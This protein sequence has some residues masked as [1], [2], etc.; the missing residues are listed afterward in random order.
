LGDKLGPDVELLLEVKVVR[1]LKTDSERHLNTRKLA[2][3]G[4]PAAARG[5]YVD[6]TEDDRHLHLVRVGKYESVLRTVPAGI[7][8][9]GIHMSVRASFG[10]PL[11]PIPSR[12]PK[13]HGFAEDVVVYEP[14]EHG[15]YTHE[16]DDV[17][18]AIESELELSSFSHIGCTY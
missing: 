11:V 5:T 16:N 7:Q 4:S 18:T 10:I 9:N 8:T 12:M 6:N 15:E 1:K 2:L 17:T 3:V 14:G 13:M